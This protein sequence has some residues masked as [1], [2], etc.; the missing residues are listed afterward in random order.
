MTVNVRSKTSLVVPPQVQRRAGIKPG[1]RVE[2]RVFGGIVN[3]IPELPSADDE[4]TPEQRKA[5]AAQLAEA[6]KR[7]YSDR[8]K[9]P[10]RLSTSCAK[11][12]GNGELDARNHEGRLV[13]SPCGV[14]GRRR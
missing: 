8:L 4:Y 13:Q 12:S 9:P 1:D 5:I 14:V 3:I 11:R 2:F 7:P 10:A 6:R